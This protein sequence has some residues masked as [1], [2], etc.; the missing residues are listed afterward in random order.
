MK[1]SFLSRKALREEAFVITV[2][3]TTECRMCRKMIYFI[4]ESFDILNS[5]LQ[6]LV[7]LV[8]VGGIVH[9]LQLYPPAW[10]NVS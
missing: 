1:S 4:I 3:A 8:K 10:R 5:D 2:A 6:F 9:I 7:F